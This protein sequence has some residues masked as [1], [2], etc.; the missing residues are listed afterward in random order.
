MLGRRLL[1][2]LRKIRGRL[3]LLQQDQ[4]VTGTDAESLGA[5]RLAGLRESVEAYLALDPLIPAMLH[6]LFLVLSAKRS[7]AEDLALGLLSADADSPLRGEDFKRT[8]FQGAERAPLAEQVARLLAAQGY[9][10]ASIRALRLAKQDTPFGVTACD[11]RL[12]AGPASPAA[13]HDAKGRWTTVTP[14]GA[15]P[16]AQ[17]GLQG[18]VDLLFARRATNEEMTQRGAPL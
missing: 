1:E 10:A 18:C 6:G 13:C 9:P 17:V 5:N 4:D 3:G 11:V 2:R 12:V 15:S 16:A 14:I 7:G 8:T